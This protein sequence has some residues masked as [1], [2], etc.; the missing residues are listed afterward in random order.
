[1]VTG[2]GLFVILLAGIVVALWKSPTKAGPTGRP[3]RG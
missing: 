1:M 3:H 2:P